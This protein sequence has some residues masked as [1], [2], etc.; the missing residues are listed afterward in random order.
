MDNNLNTLEKLAKSIKNQ[1]D[2]AGKSF[3]RWL[4]PSSGI[5]A[6]I[7]RLQKIPQEVHAIDTAM[8]NL[9]TVTDATAKRYDSFLNSAS[10]SAH[11]LGRSISSLVDQTANWA[12]LG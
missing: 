11:D 3:A 1:L 4:S 2:E 9:Y 8:T 10:K 6:V 7:K 12:K 5:S